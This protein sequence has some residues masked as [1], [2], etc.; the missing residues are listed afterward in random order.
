MKQGRGFTE[1]P[2]VCQSSAQSTGTAGVISLHFILSHC[3]AIIII[4]VNMRIATRKRDVVKHQR[5]Y[6]AG[7]HDICTMRQ[8]AQHVN[9][10]RPSLPFAYQKSSFHRKRLPLQSVKIRAIGRKERCDARPKDASSEKYTQEKKNVWEHKIAK[11]QL[12]LD[13][14]KILWAAAAAH[15]DEE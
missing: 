8:Q 4:T 7:M 3:K 9:V 13:M 1:M 10:R 6:V 2:A 12:G 5:N 14:L 15:G 11:E